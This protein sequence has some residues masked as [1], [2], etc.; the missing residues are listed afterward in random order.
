MINR[1]ITVGAFK[2]DFLGTLG[3]RA[4]IRIPKSFSTDEDQPY[5]I[6]CIE[7][8]DAL[9]RK[10]DYEGKI[11]RSSANISLLIE[12]GRRQGEAFL[13]KRASAVNA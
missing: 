9:Q 13:E 11:D 4:P 2:P 10:L 3:I 8:S 6:P 5:H 1:M 7:M 12:E